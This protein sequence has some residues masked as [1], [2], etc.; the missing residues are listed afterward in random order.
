MLR[1]EG[2]KIVLRDFLPN[3]RDPFLAL[4]S[5]SAMFTY[6]KFR[7]DRDVAESV[8]LPRLLDESRLDP[9]P[10]YNLVVEDGAGFCG[11]AGIDRIIEETAS[12]QFGWYLRSDCWGRGYA[13]EAT[14]LLLGFGFSVVNRTTMWATADPENLA[15]IRVLE[16]TGLVNRGLTDPAR[17]WRGER[18]RILFT[19]DADHWERSA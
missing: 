19:M 8:L 11:W 15:S 4:S 10:N 5:D 17:T 18:K 13:T 3:D 7:I 14:R 2:N 9:R 1:L 6:M 16:K 12:A